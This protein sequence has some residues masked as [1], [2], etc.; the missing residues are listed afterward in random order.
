MFLCTRDFN[1]STFMWIFKIGSFAEGNK[2]LITV[3]TETLCVVLSAH[4][5]GTQTDPD[6]RKIM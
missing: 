2:E 1:R 6:L 4:V 5:Q 3:V